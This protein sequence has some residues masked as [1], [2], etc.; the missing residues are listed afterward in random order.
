[1]KKIFL[2]GLIMF[3]SLT[4]TSFA[5][6]CKNSPSNNS[7]C[8]K[9]CQNIFS[10]I[11]LDLSILSPRATAADVHTC[12]PKNCCAPQVPCCAPQPPCCVPQSPCCCPKQSM[13]PE[14]KKETVLS[15]DDKPSGII[16][17]TN[18]QLSNCSCPN[19]QDK[20]SF[21]RIDLFRIFK[22][23]IL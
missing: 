18:K 21:F 15:A 14:D 7:N 9:A 22:F 13:V 11:A 12:M 16:P 2:I 8:Q 10:F 17:V 23:K 1:M 5:C 3:L 4:G 6:C 20:K 19:S